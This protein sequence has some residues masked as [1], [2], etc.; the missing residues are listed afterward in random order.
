MLKALRYLLAKTP[1][2]LIKN[3]MIFKRIC[4]LTSHGDNILLNLICWT[5][6][7]VIRK[8]FQEG[9]S[10]LNEPK[11]EEGFYYTQMKTGYKS[12]H[13]PHTHWALPVSKANPWCHGGQADLEPWSVLWGRVKGTGSDLRKNILYLG[14]SKYVAWVKQVWKRDERIRVDWNSIESSIQRKMSYQN[15]RL[16]GH[17]F[18]VNSSA[19]DSNIHFFL[20][21]LVSKERQA[22]PF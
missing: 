15:G 5:P 8:R 21:W 9:R 2:M 17:Q 3:P 6:T 18:Q 22:L 10:I 14:N 19:M 4:L 20:P 13:L 16:P 11:R 7:G 1:L 12:I